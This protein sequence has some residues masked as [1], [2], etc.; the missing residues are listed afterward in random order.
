MPRY[1]IKRDR[2]SFSQTV[3]QKKV[4]FCERNSTQKP[5]VESRYRSHQ[6]E[7]Y[8]KKYTVSNVRYVHSRASTKPS[9]CHLRM[10]PSIWIVSVKFRNPVAPP[11]ATIPRGPTYCKCI[12]PVTRREV[13]HALRGATLDGECLQSSPSAGPW[14]TATVRSSAAEVRG[15]EIATDVMMLTG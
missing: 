15:P 7:Y 10:Q 4:L 3:K 8:I 9:R 12:V 13:K 2:E 11:E 14:L 1:K 5:E 6:D